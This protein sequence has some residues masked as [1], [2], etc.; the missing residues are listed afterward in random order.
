MGAEQKTVN[1][2]YVSGGL[3]IG[4]AGEYK[5]GAVINELLSRLSCKGVAFQRKNRKASAEVIKKIN[6]NQLIE[7]KYIVAQY[8]EYSSRIEEAYLEVDSLVAFG[9]GTILSNL[10]GFYFEA[11]SRFGVDCVCEDID[12]GLV[13]ENAD[14]LISFIIDRLRD[15]VV[16][17]AK[18]PEYMEF[19][20]IGVNVVVAHAFIECVVMENPENDP[21][22]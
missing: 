3:Y 20:E 10:N 22:S 15:L 14:A 2:G 16:N 12:I 9:K 5:V 6:H 8:L 4:G 18:P 19:V 11:L 13:R 7:K 17:S 1:V 21:I